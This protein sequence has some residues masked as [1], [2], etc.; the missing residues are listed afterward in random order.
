[1]P[2]NAALAPWMLR[3]AVTRSFAPT[4]RLR[5]TAWPLLD[6]VLKASMASLA[7]FEPAWIWSKKSLDLSSPLVRAWI[8]ILMSFAM[9]E[10]HGRCSMVA[11]LLAFFGTAF[12]WVG[13]EM[14]LRRGEPV[15]GFILCF[16]SLVMVL[17]SLTRA[18]LWLATPSHL[19]Q[20]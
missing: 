4:V 2:V 16:L 3:Y 6:A 20:S 11:I 9:L 7:C 1:M 15:L 8:M 13:L 5:M 14:M 19:G 17:R 12:G 18:L 10:P